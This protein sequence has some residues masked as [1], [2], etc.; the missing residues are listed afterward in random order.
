MGKETSV[1]RTGSSIVSSPCSSGEEK[2]EVYRSQ[3]TLDNS[4]NKTMV[5]KSTGDAKVQ[6]SRGKPIGYR[7]SRRSNRTCNTDVF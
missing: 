3:H 7:N 2:K 5:S 6:L 4:L 1:E